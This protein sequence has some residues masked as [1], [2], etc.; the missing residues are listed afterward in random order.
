MITDKTGSIISSSDKSYMLQ[1]EY[2]LLISNL[3]QQ[4]IK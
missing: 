4:K 3:D 2:Q 1:E